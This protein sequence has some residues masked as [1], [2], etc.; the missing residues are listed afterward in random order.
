M[1]LSLSPLDE[2]DAPEKP[3]VVDW[4]E[5]HVDL[6]WEPPKSDGG[7]PIQEYVI[8]K[9]EKGNP[10]WVNAATVPGNKTKVRS[11]FCLRY[12]LLHSGYHR[13]CSDAFQGTVPGLEKDH[14]YEFRVIAKN[15][16]GPSEPS[17]PT[18]TVIARSRHCKFR[19]ERA[20]FSH[21]SPH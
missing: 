2:P 20:N 5:D 3:E 14:E 21:S 8:Q 4:D 16:A 9:K 6:K 19:L 7:S 13:E 12:F 11:I 18:D 17:E 10:Y 1:T 15:K